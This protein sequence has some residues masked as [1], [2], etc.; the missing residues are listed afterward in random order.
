LIPLTNFMASGAGVSASAVT[1]ESSQTWEGNTL[2]IGGNLIGSGT[3]TLRPYAV[4]SSIGVAGGSGTL[5]VDDALL[6]YIQPGFSNLVIGRTD[7]TGSININA[8]TFSNPTRLLSPDG[9][10]ITLNGG[11]TANG[12]GDALIIAG[13][14]FLNPAGY[15]L[16]APN[17][18]WLVYS[19]NPMDTIEGMDVYNKRYNVEYPSTVGVGTGNY[20][21]YSTE[22]VLSVTAY[23]QSR[24]YGEN[25]PELT[26]TAAGFIDGDIAEGILTGSLSTVAGLNSDVGDYAITQGSLAGSIGYILDYTQANLTITPAPLTVTADD[27]SKVYGDPNPVLTAHYS[28]LKGSDTEAVVSGL[29]LTT[30]AT[31]GSDVGSYT[32]T[33]ANGTASNYTLI[34]VDGVL[35][36]TALSEP[37]PSTNNALSEPLQIVIETAQSLALELDADSPGGGVVWGGGRYRSDSPMLYVANEGETLNG[38]LAFVEVP[39]IKTDIF[40]YGDRNS[41]DFFNVFVVNG[42]INLPGQVANQAIED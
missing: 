1:T 42:G 22:P 27:K 3:M 28:G 14:N 41:E 25:N 10:N 21:L 23:A 13:K 9:G 7:G 4:N 12:T 5:Q 33:A 8:V 16:D 40:S 26:Y 2:T 29:T 20:M 11:I 34:F 30:P 37:L 36:V 32:I 35:T 39:D 38:G 6:G 18:R 17:G 24:E 19:S 15:G 31:N